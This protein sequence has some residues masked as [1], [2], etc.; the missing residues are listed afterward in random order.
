M[1]R[2]KDKSFI[3]YEF[4]TGEAVQACIREGLGQLLEYAYYPAEERAKKLIIVSP[5]PI[6]DYSRDFIRS[7]RSRFGLPVYYVRYDKASRQLGKR[8]Y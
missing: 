7:L 5:N 2:D 8:E 4:K 3:Y 6:D 1:V